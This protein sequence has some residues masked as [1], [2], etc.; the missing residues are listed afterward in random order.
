MSSKIVIGS[1]ESKLAVIQSNIVI[2]YLNNKNIDTELIT[3]KTTGDKILDRR[4]DQIGGKGLFVKEL[5]LALREGRCDYCVHSLKDMPMEMPADLPIVCFS[6]REDPRDVLVLPEGVSELDL[7]KPIGT[8]SLRRIL[9]LKEIYPE[10]TFESVRGNLQTRLRKLDEGQYSGLILAAAGLKRL[11]LENRISRYFETDEVIPAAGQGIL[12]I[13]GRAESAISNEIFD[14]FTDKGVT[15]VALAERAFVRTLDGGCSSPIAAYAQIVGAGLKITGLYVKEGTEKVF[16]D[17]ESGHPDDAEIIG[18]R[19]ARKLLLQCGK[20]NGAGKVWLVGAGPGDAGLF[21]RKGYDVLKQAEVVVYDSLVSDAILSMI[22]ENA[23]KIDAGKRAGNHKIRQEETNRI[24]LQEAL[25][26][27][28][29]VRLK[30]GDPFL[31]GRGGEELELLSEH[32]IEYEVVPGI[33]SAISVPAYNGIP[34]TH[35]DFCSSVH[36]IT[37]HKKQGED[38]NINFK[39]LVETEGTLVF[40]MGVSAMVDICENLLMAGMDPDMPAAILQSGTTAGQRRVVATISTLPEESK[41]A[42]IGSPGIIVVGKVCSLADNYAWYEKM[43]LF[44]QKILVTRPKELVSTMAEKLRNLG[45]EVI[46]LPAI[47]TEPIKD[48]SKLA[49]ALDNIREYGWVAF[50]SPSGVRI[51]FDELENA[52]KDIRSLGH[53]KVAALGEGTRKELKKYG[54]IADLMPET[55]DGEALGEAIAKNA[56]PGT[57]ILLPR[58]AIGNK[59]ILEKLKDFQV[60]DIPTYDTVS[61]SQDV[62][63][64][65]EEI[66]LGQ[67][68]TVAFTSSSSVKAFVAAYPNADFTKLTAAC[69][70]RQTRETAEGFGMNCYMAKKATIDS[71]VEAIVEGK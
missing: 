55:Y 59:E 44:G 1:R 12:A 41:K 70:G 11:G 36:I 48:N 49:T 39:A 62:L 61:C 18:T 51:F 22:P 50:T 23:K 68:R 29:V 27:Q 14:E 63:D 3:M 13:Q 16:I 4:L 15:A 64:I 53:I 45:A 69:I 67:I 57:K 58:A 52:Q 65:E 7:S 40:L 66:L 56:E 21:T 54:I 71:L 19:L 25:K 47:K 26:G 5:E 8:S 20:E 24:L 31:F 17:S 33:T 46:E 37:G 60:D 30:G 10:A 6:K 38:Y 32:G 9:Q 28:R 43:P 42:R 35:R 34:V 2:D